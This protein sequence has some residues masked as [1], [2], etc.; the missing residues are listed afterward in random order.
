MEKD[1]YYFS[2]DSN[3]RNDIKIVRLRRAHKMEGFGIYWGIIEMLREAA[4]HSLPISSIEDIA[5]DL[6]ADE[7]KVRSIIS[8]FDLFI[9][10]DN[11]FSSARLSRAMEEFE[12]RKNRYRRAGHKGGK[13]SVKQRLSDATASVEQVSSIKGKGKGKGKG[14]EK[15]NSDDESSLTPPAVSPYGSAVL[16]DIEVLKTECLADQINFGE[17]ICRQTGI[18]P[19]GVPTALEDFNGH[20]RSI[21]D[22]IKS[23][24]DYRS[25]FKNW[26][27]K[28]ELSKYGNRK[29]IL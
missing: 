3:A 15:V 17:H 27:G 5:Y 9:I 22:V 12:E 10:A 21:Q 18:K 7:E 28:Q 24:K 13:A 29:M 16:R 20:L 8:D 11:T 25:H 26:L 23:S 19:G 6:D 2:H 4:G 14:K 1:A